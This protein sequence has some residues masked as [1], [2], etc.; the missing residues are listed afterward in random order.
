[1]RKI[2]AILLLILGATGCTTVTVSRKGGRDM[3]LVSTSSWEFLNAIPIVAGNPEKP[4]AVSTVWFTDTATVDWNMRALDRTMRKYKATGF[5]SLT[6]YMTEETIFIILFKRRTCHTS[7]EFTYS[8]PIT[9]E[10]AE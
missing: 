7:A 1:M 2:L 5:D 9:S 10:I 3:C 8:A 4:N 6:S